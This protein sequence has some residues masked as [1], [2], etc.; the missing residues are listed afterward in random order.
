M[1][2]PAVT[3]GAFS[4]SP[5]TTVARMQLTATIRPRPEPGATNI[6]GFEMKVITTEGPDYDTAKSAL[7]TRVPD[8]W[9]MLSVRS[10]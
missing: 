5:A 9:Q 2:A 6:D 1:Y 7:E 8:G 10:H 3:R 4:S